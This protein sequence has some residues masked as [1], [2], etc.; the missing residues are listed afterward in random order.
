MTKINYK[1]KYLELKKASQVIHKYQSKLDRE[2]Q[3]VI[4]YLQRIIKRSLSIKFK[5]KRKKL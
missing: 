4:N 2:L 1:K 3:I 5:S